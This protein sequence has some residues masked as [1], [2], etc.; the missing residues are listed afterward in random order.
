MSKWSCK[1]GAAFTTEVRLLKHYAWADK[2]PTAN[3]RTAHGTAALTQAV[4][5][6]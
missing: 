3:A 1:C 5:D 6:G 4:L 2:L